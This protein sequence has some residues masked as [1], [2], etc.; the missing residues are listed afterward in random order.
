MV[1]CEHLDRVRGIVWSWLNIKRKVLKHETGHVFLNTATK[2]TVFPC[3]IKKIVKKC[4][5]EGI[6]IPTLA[7]YLD[8]D[9]WSYYNFNE[10][11][12]HYSIVVQTQQIELHFL[13]HSNRET[14]FLGICFTILFM[15]TD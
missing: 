2:T 7:L 5:Q 3:T 12:K 15:F 11:Q 10:T 4:P 9:V 6:R 8:P 14:H 13:S 1:M